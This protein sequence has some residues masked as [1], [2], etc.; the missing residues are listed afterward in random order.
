MTRRRSRGVAFALTAALTGLLLS[1]PGAA[2]AATTDTTASWW[3]LNQ[4]IGDTVADASGNGA[5]A[6]VSGNVGWSA[7]AASFRGSTGQQIAT[8]RP[9]LDTTES[10]SVSAWVEPAKLDG[11]TT[12]GDVEAV[13][14][15][16]GAWVADVPTH[17]LAPGATFAWTAHYGTGWE[18]INYSVTIV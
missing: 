13:D 9:V 7:G 15:T 18:G 8:G 4:A 6:T 5:T 14:T 16:L 17:K 11:W 3:P 12:F 1:A 10:F 2:G